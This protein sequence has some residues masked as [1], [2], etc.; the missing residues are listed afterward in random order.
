MLYLVWYDADAQRP[1]GE[2]IREASAAYTRRFN[3]AP[4]LVLVNLADSTASAAIE[5]RAERTVQPHHF[6]VGRSDEQIPERGAPVD[7]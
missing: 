6:W 3:V 5:V 1:V 2:K 4:N 7:G